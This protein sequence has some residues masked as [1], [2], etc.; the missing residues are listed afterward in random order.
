[1]AQK[2]Q[3]ELPATLS[4][5]QEDLTEEIVQQTAYLQLQ[6]KEWWAKEANPFISEQ[7]QKLYENEVIRQLDLVQ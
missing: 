4:N 6:A 2:Y 1:M 5:V 3:E 7:Y